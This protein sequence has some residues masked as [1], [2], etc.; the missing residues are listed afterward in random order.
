MQMTK[1]FTQLK[2]RKS[3]KNHDL[4]FQEFPDC[5]SL[6][7]SDNSSFSTASTVSISLQDDPSIDELDYIFELSSKSRYHKQDVHLSSKKELDL[8]LARLT[9]LLERGGKLRLSSQDYYS[10]A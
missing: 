7:S 9:G 1:L 10:L 2:A 5:A 8:E 3:N 4:Q 6:S